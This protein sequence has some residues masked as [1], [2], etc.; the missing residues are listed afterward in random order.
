M[1]PTAATRTPARLI[2]LCLGGLLLLACLASQIR[3][4]WAGFFF[5]DDFTFLV[6]YRQ[7]LHPEQWLSVANFGRF[8]SRNL[9][10]WSVLGMAGPDP[11]VFLLLNLFWASLTAALWWVFLKPLSTRIATFGAWCWLVSGATMANVVWASNSQHLLAHVFMAGYLCIVGAWHRSRHPAWAL[12]S[13]P[14]FLIGLG[15]N[16][17]VAVALSWSALCIVQARLEKGTWVL[18]CAWVI[19]A[20]MAALLLQTLAPTQV[21]AYEVAW[22]WHVISTNLAHYYGH[23]GV[24]IFGAAWLSCHA[25]QHWRAGALLRAWLM[26]APILCLLPFL[27]LVH[28]RYLNYAALSHFFLLTALL[29]QWSLAAGRSRL[30]IGSAILVLGMLAL[31]STY[32]QHMK[33]WRHPMGGQQLAQVRSTA[34]AIEAYPQ[35]PKSRICIQGPPQ[36]RPPSHGTTQAFWIQLGHGSAFVALVDDRLQY[37]PAPSPDPCQLTIAAPELYPPVPRPLAPKSAHEPT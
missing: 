11:K 21:G 18:V 29:S 36:A 24:A 27:P 6:H 31:H 28:Q 10:W 8:V 15:S 17:L 32:R 1:H 7:D 37:V 19:Q 3:H 5:Q 12:A 25:W 16:V 33:A 26:L 23:A 20:T 9:Y 2:L 14:V 4:A 13:I 35:P 34:R 22:S 30:A